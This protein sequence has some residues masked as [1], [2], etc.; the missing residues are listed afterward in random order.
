MSSDEFPL[1]LTKKGQIKMATPVRTHAWQTCLAKLYIIL[2]DMSM[3]VFSSYN[4]CISSCIYPISSL[5]DTNQKM[6][7]RLW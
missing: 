6:L 5:S 3:I 7:Y 4:N 1:A 2:M